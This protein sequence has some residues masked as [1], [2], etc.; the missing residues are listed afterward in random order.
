MFV[1]LEW[2]VHFEAGERADRGISRRVRASRRLHVGPWERRSSAVAAVIVIG[3]H[4][5]CT[6]HAACRRP[7][8]F[9][10]RDI[11]ATPIEM[12]TNGTGCDY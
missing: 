4:A 10:A 8:R 7:C 9:R 6:D 3:Y 11:R 5:F 12:R 1:Q 2:P